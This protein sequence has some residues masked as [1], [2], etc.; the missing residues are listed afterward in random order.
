MKIQALAVVTVLAL[1]CA[2]ARG[3]GMLIPKDTSV[4]PL[5]IK[6]QRVDIRV[7]D[8]VHVLKSS[9]PVGIV[10]YGFD[11]YVSYGY[12]GGLNLIILR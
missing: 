5:A 11:Q 12:P 4:P 1:A 9:K 8:G 2:S 10:A 3:S 7:K 6:H